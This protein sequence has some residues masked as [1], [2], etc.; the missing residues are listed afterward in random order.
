[1]THIGGGYENYSLHGL[2]N[3]R[4]KHMIK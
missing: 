2:Q 3:N 1:M 4:L